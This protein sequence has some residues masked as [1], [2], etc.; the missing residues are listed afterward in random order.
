MSI[1]SSEEQVP[2]A[3]SHS[4]LLHNNE[5]EETILCECTIHLIPKLNTVLGEKSLKT[6]LYV[7]I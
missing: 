4:G 5:N 1:P 6:M 7:I 2:V 3:C